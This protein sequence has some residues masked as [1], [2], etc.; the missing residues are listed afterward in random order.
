[1]FTPVLDL[2]V[3]YRCSYF[4]LTDETGADTGDGTKW[5]GVSGLSSAAIVEAIITVVNSS[6]TSTDLDVT[7]NISG[8]SPITGN[9]ALGDHVGTYPDGLYS[10]VYKLKAGTFAITAFADYS[11]TVVS[12]VKVTAAAHGLETGEYVIITGTTNYNGTFQI[13]KIDA[14]NFYILATWV[15]TQTGTGQRYYVTTFKPYVY[16]RLEGRRDRMY[17]SISRMV[18]G[19]NRDK[20][21]D[22]AD[23]VSALLMVIKSAISSANTT[24]LANLQAEANQILNFHDID[25]SF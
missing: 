21:Q 14:S 25:T 4:R 17:A 9:V 19:V 22:D 16:C 20:W 6:G 13:T 1:M 3:V 10:L 5:D 2:D 7:T 15:I 18:P 12:T 23:K 11:A 8:A 24:A